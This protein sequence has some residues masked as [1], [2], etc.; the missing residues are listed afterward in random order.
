M[1]RNSNLQA[2]T[3][4]KSAK[5]LMG[6]QTLTIFPRH[7]TTPDSEYRLSPAKLVFGCPIKDFLPLK[8]G[9]FSSSEV[10]VDC[11]ENRNFCQFSSE[12]PLQSTLSHC[13]S[14]HHLQLQPAR[15]WIS[16]MFRHFQLLLYLLL[17]ISILR[18]SNITLHLYSYVTICGL[19]KVPV[20]NK[21]ERPGTF[22]N[23]QGR[24]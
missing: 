8:P 21:R 13:H 6:L 7:Q 22:S 5:R 12:P 18:M 20:Y 10:C 17:Q 16:Q 9:N 11:R 19:I 14:H 1:W 2:E 3:T 23:W 24:I 4:I 15:P